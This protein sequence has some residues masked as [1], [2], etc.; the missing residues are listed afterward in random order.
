MLI[1]PHH[2]MHFELAP[3]YRSSDGGVS[4]NSLGY[5]GPEF[6]VR[7]QDNVM[8][9]VCM[10]DSGTYCAGL[11]DGETWPEFLSAHLNKK[12][13]SEVI[14]AGVPA[15]LS[16]EFLLSFIFKIEELRPDWLIIYPTITDAAARRCGVMSRD[17]REYC[18]SWVDR[19]RLRSVRDLRGFSRHGGT[20]AYRVR[21]LLDGSFGR[22]RILEGS[23]DVFAA[24]IRDLA[25]LATSRGIHVLLLCPGIRGA[26]GAGG[27]E[28]IAMAQNQVAMEQIGGELSL[29]VLDMGTLVGH[30]PG[31]DE[32]SAYYLDS[33]HLS[34]AGA[35]QFASVVAQTVLEQ[36][37]QHDRCQQ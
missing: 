8:R 36:G 25:A 24:N 29:P 33:V 35:D 1:R 3:N 17:Y 19:T 4:H 23:S 2:Y 16:S 18:R 6:T 28:S 34:P 32:T 10:G 9:V 30:P 37:A 26:G 27:P 5:R 12:R 11:R 20:I 15:Y 13:K 14:N 7:K 31:R 22:N 21:N